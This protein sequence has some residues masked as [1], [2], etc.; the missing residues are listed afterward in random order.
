MTIIASL[1]I[2]LVLGGG[3]SFAAQ[4][5]LPGDVLYRVKADI[6]EEVIGA[7]TLS[8]EGKAN[9]NARR[10]ERRPEEATELVAEGKL[11]AEVRADIE[12]RLKEH[13]NDS[14]EETRKLESGGQNE[15]AIEARSD[16]ESRLEGHASIAVLLNVYLEGE[17]RSQVEK[18]LETNQEKLIQFKNNPENFEETKNNL[19]GTMIKIAG[20]VNKNDFFQRLEIIANDV[21]QANPEEEIKRLNEEVKKIES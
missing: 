17:S 8:T 13:V 16:L 1:V 10:A 6:N 20:R 3:T 14:E 9:W 19:L 15:A 4:S 7:L 5:A 21:T 11:N 12:A 2:A 18:L